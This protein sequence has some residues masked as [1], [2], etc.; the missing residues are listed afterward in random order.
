[1]LPTPRVIAIDDQ[2]EHLERLI[3]GLNRHGTACLPI[4]FTGEI[5]VIPSCPYVRVIF[6]DLHL[7][8]G[9]SGDRIQDFNTIATLLENRIKPTGP[10]M[11]ILWTMYP[12]QADALGALLAGRLQN[13]S[14]PFSVQALDKNTYL[15]SP[16]SAEGLQTLVNAIDQST[17]E[18]P[19]FGALLNWEDRVLGAAN[20]TVSSIMELAEASAGGNKPNQQVGR[21]L[22]N[23]A[24]EAVGTGH[25]EEDRFRAVNEGLLPILGDRIAS[26]R[27]LDEDDEMWKAALGSS[28]TK[29]KLNQDEAAKLNRLIHIDLLPSN[30]DGTEHGTVIDLPSKFSASKFSGS[31]FAQTFDVT[32]TEAAEKQF[33]YKSSEG[34]SNLQWVL[35]QTQAACDY[36]QNQPGPLP[37]HLGLCLPTSAERS[38]RAPDALWR[39][40]CFEYDG[41]PCFL[42]V[43]ARFHVSLPREEVEHASRRFR[44]REQIL[45]YLICWIHSYGSR[46]GIISFESRDK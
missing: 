33:W 14:K 15:E 17:T 16:G 28:N 23:L 25:V 36:T 22:S 21:L 20:D 32:E 31:L 40:P 46:P 18:H 19:Q 9:S 2:V 45:N 3:Q 12:D 8:A 4:H 29:S 27:A 5:E 38:G 7:I 42:H 6:A 1:M 37:F 26:M 13:V 24:S 43:N 41:K 39:S 34:L 35:V 30:S 44:L 11:I 10:Y